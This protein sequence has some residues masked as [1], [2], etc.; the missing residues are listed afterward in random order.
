MGKS[1]PRVAMPTISRE[2]L[3]V[4]GETA[5]RVPPMQP[6]EAPRL[7]VDRAAAT[8]RSRTPTLAPE[9][10]AALHDRCAEIVREMPSQIFQTLI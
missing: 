6:D 9:Q 1:R 3:N 5:W 4:D 8:R 2:A 7:F 10:D